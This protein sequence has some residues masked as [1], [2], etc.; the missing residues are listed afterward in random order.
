MD[1]TI[2][3][4]SQV[5]QDTEPTP[6]TRT[7]PCAANHQSDEMDNTTSTN[8]CIG[9][10]SRVVES[11]SWINAHE[12]PAR[13]MQPLQRI[14][15]TVAPEQTLRCGRAGHY[16]VVD[17]SAFHTT[18]I[19]TSGWPRYVASAPNSTTDPLP[20]GA[21]AIAARPATCCKPTAHPDASVSLSA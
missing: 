16:F 12:K 20:N 13:S 10:P 5:S 17:I 7:V 1:T 15:T 2:A 18:R 4:V 9:T 3:G 8:A 14:Q 11:R 19:V 6:V 21:R